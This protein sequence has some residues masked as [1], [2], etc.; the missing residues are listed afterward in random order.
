[1]G[2]VKKFEDYKIVNYRDLLTGK[3]LS[4]EYYINKD[5]NKKPY[6][7]KS[8]MLV[9]IDDKKTI[10]TK[11]FYLTDKQAKEYNEIS[12]EIIKLQ[13]EQEKILKIKN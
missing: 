9:V 1:M 3:T 7:L 2:N 10:P 13:E 6:I 8:D 4:P 12:E 5:K 11:A